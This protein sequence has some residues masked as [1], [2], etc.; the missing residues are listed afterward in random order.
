MSPRDAQGREITWRN[1]AALDG[2]V[3]RLSGVADRLA[4]KNRSLRQ[5]HSVLADKVRVAGPN[6]YL[7]AA[8]CVIAGLC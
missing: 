8:S 6:K 4:E 3:R 2:Y 7:A 5:W 1:A